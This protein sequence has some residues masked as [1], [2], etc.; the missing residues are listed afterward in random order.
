[1]D[2]LITTA[3]TTSGLASQVLDYLSHPY[4]ALAVGG[5]MPWLHPDVPPPVDLTMISLP[6]LYGHFPITRIVPVIPS[7][8]GNIATSL[9][10]RWQ[11]LQPTLS[12]VRDNMCRHI[13]I[14]AEIIHNL[15]PVTAN[16]YNSVGLYTHCSTQ[17]TPSTFVQ[18]EPDGRLDVVQQLGQLPKT[19]G[20]THVIQIIREF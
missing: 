11:E 16:F 12:D 1:M 3:V 13:L 6:S 20:V 4:Y 19:P 8:E 10:E 2:I 18:T 17:P 14:E 15:L 5:D 9:D 7:R